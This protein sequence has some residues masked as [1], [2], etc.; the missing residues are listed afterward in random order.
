MVERYIRIRPDIKKREAVE[1][2][3]PTGRTHRKLVALFEHLKKFESINKRLQRDDS[4]M[5]D[6]RVMSDTLIAEY[7]RVVEHIKDAEK[8]VHTPS[9][10]CVIVK[11]IMGAALSPTAT[12]TLKRFVVAGPA[13]KKRKEREDDYASL[14][15]Q[16]KTKKG[17]QPAP[18]RH[19]A[20][21]VNIIPPTPNKVER[22]FTQCRLVLTPQWSSMS[23]ANFEQ[24]AF[25]RANRE[26][27]DVTMVVS[28]RE[29]KVC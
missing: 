11:V 21:L 2:L 26:M 17:R 25:L 10:E 24:L 5:D 20:P 23:P 19:Y 28:V 6:V 18:T 7:P 14:L 4:S 3:V 12:E 13:E 1:E 16:G 29:R 15:L 22:L 9:F 27:W 8:I